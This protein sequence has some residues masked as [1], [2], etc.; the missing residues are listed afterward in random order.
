MRG[1]HHVD[2]QQPFGNL[3]R[4][5]RRRASRSALLPG[6]ICD[7]P[8]TVNAPEKART[9]DNVEFHISSIQ[10]LLLTSTFTSD[11]TCHTLDAS[12]LQQV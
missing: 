12:S 9:S 8:H 2:A 5:N 4:C 6:W 11:T 1:V 3:E 7:G 10:L